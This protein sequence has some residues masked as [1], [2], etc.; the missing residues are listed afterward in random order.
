MPKIPAAGELAEILS[1]KSI[2]LH[3]KHA[4]RMVLLSSPL[5]YAGIVFFL[6]LDLYVTIYQAVCFRS[7]GIPTVRRSDYIIYDRGRLPYLN[8]IE[9][10]GC[11]YC[12]YANGLLAYVVEITARTEQHF[13][14]IKHHGRVTHPHS[15]YSHFLPYGD[16][17]AFQK[18]FNK[19]RKDFVDI[20][21]APEDGSKIK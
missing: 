2:W 6:M 1:P 13:C 11:L 14:P 8:W 17:R 20:K 10:L 5:I 4:R 9:K 12:S 18:G 21:P 3:L 19:V 15:R 7:N 16:G